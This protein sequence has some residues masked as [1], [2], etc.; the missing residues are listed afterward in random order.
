M[1]D[2]VSNSDTIFSF[3]LT[4]GDAESR[5]LPSTFQFLQL[6]SF[7]SCQ[8]GALER[9]LTAQRQR[10]NFSSS[11][12]VCCFLICLFLFILFWSLADFF[13]FCYSV[14]LAIFYSNRDNS[15]IAAI[16]YNLY[17]YNIYIYKSIY[18]DILFC[19]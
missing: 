2:C 10:I 4:L 11:T 6:L 1:W 8:K 17:I 5:T 16:N 9:V 15:F 14:I 12:T 3:K 7:R 13:L 18:M 19:F